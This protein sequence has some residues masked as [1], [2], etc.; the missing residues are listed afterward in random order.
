[1]RITFSLR[2]LIFGSFSPGIATLLPSVVV[3]KDTGDASLKLPGKDSGLP[4]D[5]DKPKPHCEHGKDRDGRCKPP[6]HHCEHGKDKKG[7]CWPKPCP[8]GRKDNGDCKPPR[9]VGSR[10]LREI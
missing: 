9:C 8:N 1:M 2:V 10:C 3:P 7:N 4:S 5:K 6:P